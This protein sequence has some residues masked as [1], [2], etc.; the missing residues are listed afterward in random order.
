M[1]CLALDTLIS[2]KLAGK[3]FHSMLVKPFGKIFNLD[4]L[5]FQKWLFSTYDLFFSNFCDRFWVCARSCEGPSTTI[6]SLELFLFYSFNFGKV[7]FR[8][9]NVILKCSLGQ[10][11]HILKSKAL[12]MP[13]KSFGN[14]IYH[15]REEYHFENIY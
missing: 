3:S 1:A 13:C 6:D 2:N 15:L 9:S 7:S 4:F 8:T 11:V 14:V 10:I 12:S 5:A